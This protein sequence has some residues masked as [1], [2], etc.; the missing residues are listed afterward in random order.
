M[1]QALEKGVIHKRLVKNQ[2]PK[3]EAQL[4]VVEITDEVL[5]RRCSRCFLTIHDPISGG[6][7]PSDLCD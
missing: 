4:G 6:E 1:K 2:C 5:T 3:C 7:F